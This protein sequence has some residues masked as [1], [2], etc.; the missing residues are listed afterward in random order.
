MAEKGGKGGG[1]RTVQ[2]QVNPE[3]LTCIMIQ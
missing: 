1:L 3:A 2:C